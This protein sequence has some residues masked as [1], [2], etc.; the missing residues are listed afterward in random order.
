MTDHELI[1]QALIEYEEEKWA[2]I[3]S[4]EQD[5]LNNLISDYKDKV[6]QEEE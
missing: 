4:D 1:L 3:N 5:K 2:Y 6:K